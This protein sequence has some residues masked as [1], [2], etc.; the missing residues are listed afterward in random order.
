MILVV[1]LI[2][3]SVVRPST[4]CFPRLPPFVSKIF[5][6]I[7]EM[8]FSGLFREVPWLSGA[9][10]GRPRPV[11]ILQTLDDLRFL[12]FFSIVLAATREPPR[13][14]FLRRTSSVLEVSSA[15]AHVL[16]VFLIPTKVKA[17][18]SYLPPELIAALACAP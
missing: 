12:Y 1:T 13:S 4:R 17:A 18:R 6:V 14:S 7:E 8:R 5:V 16:T 2:S 10:P 15:I 3:Q 9:Y 11:G